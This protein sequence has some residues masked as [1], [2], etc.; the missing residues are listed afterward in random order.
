MTSTMLAVIAV[1]FPTRIGWPAMHPSPKKS[2]GCKIANDG[3]FAHSAE[4]SYFDRTLLNVHDGIGWRTLLK[5]DLSFLEMSDFSVHTRRI[6][7]SLRVEFRFFLRRGFGLTFNAAHTLRP[8]LTPWRCGS[9]IPL[10][11]L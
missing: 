7:E 2:P 8:K 11:P 1:A 10:M 5:N 9:S 3:L 4:G 6:E